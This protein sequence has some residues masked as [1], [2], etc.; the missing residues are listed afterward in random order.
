MFL[1]C[2]YTQLVL[3]EHVVGTNQF[4]LRLLFKYR[5]GRREQSVEYEEGGQD[6]CSLGGEDREDEFH[7]EAVSR[8]T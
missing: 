5:K 7:L 6:N 3:I 4:Y 8:Q 2:V 1:T